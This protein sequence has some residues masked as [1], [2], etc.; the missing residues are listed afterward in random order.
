MTRPT[1]GPKENRGFDP[2]EYALTR[3]G[4]W[5]DEPWDGD[6]VAKVDQKIFC[7]MGDGSTVGVKAGANRAEA[8]EW[9]HE[10]PD[11]ATVMPYI[12]RSGW[13]TLRVGGAISNGELRVAIDESY[14]R[15][16]AKVPKSR[17][18]ADWDTV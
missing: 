5:R 13:N 7:F 16:V 9:L 4:A 10:F 3:P 18:P 14:R 12:G 2:V 6:V 11:D 1:S 17:R 15:V 8:D